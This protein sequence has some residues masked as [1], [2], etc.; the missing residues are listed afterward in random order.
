MIYLYGDSH[1][2]FSF[3]GLSLPH[4]CRREYSVTMHRIGRDKRVVKWT[5]CT[6]DDITV[7]AFGEVDCRAH[8]GKQIELGRN[9]NDIISVLATEY[10]DTLRRTSPGRIIVVAVIPPTTSADL[11]K[12]QPNIRAS[13]YPFVS[14]DQDRLRYT[15]KLN[16]RLSDICKEHSITF[17]NPYAPYTRED[18]FLKRELCDT[19]GLH[20]GNSSYVVNSFMTLVQQL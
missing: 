15:N 4:E 8:V 3:R 17:F 20:V 10:I 19:I 9:E 2:E 5:P 11:L 1:A 18:G 6:P 16:A 7:F 13:D 14:S 12:S